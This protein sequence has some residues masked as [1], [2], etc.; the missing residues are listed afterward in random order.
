[1]SVNTWKELG[2]LSRIPTGRV[3]ER[4]IQVKGSACAKAQR[5]ELAWKI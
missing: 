2:N 3:C 4:I 5:H 1:M